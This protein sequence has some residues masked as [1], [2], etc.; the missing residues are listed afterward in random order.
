[1]L[2]DCAKR[3]R[4][5]CYLF[6]LQSAQFF[7]EFFHPFCPEDQQRFHE[8][9]TQFVKQSVDDFGMAYDASIRELMNQLSLLDEQIT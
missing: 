9:I 7:S 1:M 3:R 8:D 4:L 2:A 5:D 6:L